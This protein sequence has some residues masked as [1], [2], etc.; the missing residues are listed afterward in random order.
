MHPLS[1][2]Y[3]ILDSS[4]PKFMRFAPG[5]SSGRHE[6]EA[7]RTLLSVAEGQ[8]EFLARLADYCETRE[9]DVVRGQYPIAYTEL[10]DL[11][12]AFLLRKASEFQR[13]DT[14]AVQAVLQSIANDEDRAWGEE[15]LGMC[16]AHEEIL[17]GLLATPV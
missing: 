14:R 2:I 9:I 3:W 1:R 8:D 16:R 15:A 11:S 4:F 10:H 7:V 6:D 5:W 17:A 13:R 12:T